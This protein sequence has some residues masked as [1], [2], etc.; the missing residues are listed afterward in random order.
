M[1]IRIS[2]IIPAYNTSEWIE[3]CINSLI[4]QSSSLYE[5]LIIDDNST[6]NTLAI[7]QRY[8]AINTTI[9]VFE[10]DQN[11]GP[12]YA[13]NYGISKANGDYILFVDSDDLLRQDTVEVL[14][15]KT[16]EGAYDA[17]YFNAEAFG[18]KEYRDASNYQRSVGALET[19]GITGQR[20]FDITYPHDYFASP[21]LCLYKKKVINDADIA[22]PEGIFFEDEFFSFVFVQEAQSICYINESFYKR[23]YRKGSTVTTKNNCDKFA[24]YHKCFAMI[25]NYIFRKYGCEL[26]YSIKQYILDMYIAIIEAYHTLECKPDDSEW[27]AYIHSFDKFF[28]QNDYCGHNLGLLIS[29]EHILL[30]ESQNNLRFHEGFLSL[31][32]V[33]GMID[34]LYKEI[35]NMIPLGNERIH[36]GI[37]GN[38]NHTS[39]LY[40]AYKYYYGDIKADVS[41]LT[42]DTIE[43]CDKMKLD[44]IFISSFKYRKEMYANAQR[45][46]D[47]KRIIYV[48]NSLYKDVFSSFSNHIQLID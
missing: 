38:G 5:I 22:F 15:S 16:I 10:L 23:R 29:L 31:E 45:Y 13:R 28:V 1:G 24:D 40:S 47:K 14:T 44:Y 2:A 26:S 27:S 9:K 17:I 42:T 37:Y 46:F 30:R 48:Y 8:E 32:N 25:N 34:E 19:N 39:G 43:C 35:L 41:I 33:K 3:D 21:C 20:F 11:Y 7:A 6:D 18:L 36:I 12:G 4:N